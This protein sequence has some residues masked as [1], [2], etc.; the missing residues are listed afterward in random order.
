MT[1]RTLLRTLG[2]ITIGFWGVITFKT[3]SHLSKPSPKKV[4]ISKS[5]LEKIKELHLFAD[6]IIV[7][8][9]QKYLVFSR[10][11]PHLGCK[12]NYDPEKELIVCPCHQSKFYLTGKYIEGPAKR[13][14]QK[15]PFE[16]NEEGIK[17]EIS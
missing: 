3:L 7:K 6:I 15:L 5:E 13:D 9:E 17:V 1:R 14:L 12:L 10:K 2:L 16:Y 4:F 11:C 8:K